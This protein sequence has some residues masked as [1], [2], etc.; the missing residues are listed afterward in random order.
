MSQ[1]SNIKSFTT[2]RTS[3]PRQPEA[4]RRFT[5]LASQTPA[6]GMSTAHHAGLKTTSISSITA[7]PHITEILSALGPDATEQDLDEAIASHVAAGN[8]ILPEDIK[9]F[10][11]E[12]M[13]RRKATTGA[14]VGGAAVLL[15][16]ARGEKEGKQALARGMGE[17]ADRVTV[18]RR[19]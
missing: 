12:P 4:P 8:A 10:Y 15:N 14:D 17:W 6:A 5:R 16:M 3:E 18:E 11:L 19:E 1:E 2:P 13:R 9:P 7:H